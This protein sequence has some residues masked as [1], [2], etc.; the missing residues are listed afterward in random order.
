M[1]G[2]LI[3]SIVEE[4]QEG[5]NGDDW[6]YWVEAKAFNEGLKGKGRIEVGKHTL[7]SGARQAPPGPPAPVEMA[8]GDCSQHVSVHLSLQATEVDL[9]KN[10]V[11]ETNIDVTLHFP[12]PGEPPLVH[13]H[14]ITVGV[15]ESPTLT[16]ETTI[17]SVVVRLV[18]SSE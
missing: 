9:F 16:G 8:A 1:E 6:K 15:V 12:E 4:A 14:E 2:K 13:D 7:S 17:F 10:D 11:G 3:F 5:P 18:L